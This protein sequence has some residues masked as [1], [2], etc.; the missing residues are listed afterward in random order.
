MICTYCEKTIT[1]EFPTNYYVSMTGQ[2]AETGFAVHISCFVP[3]LWE[4]EKEDPGM[5]E[6]LEI[7]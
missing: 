2:D 4:Q 5:R 3:W 6:L 7:R 1:K